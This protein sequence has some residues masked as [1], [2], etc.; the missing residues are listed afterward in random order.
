[1]TDP[2]LDKMLI[3]ILLN[4]FTN[5]SKLIKNLNTSG[6]LLSSIRLVLLLFYANNE[7]GKFFEDGR[8]M[9]IRLFLALHDQVI[10]A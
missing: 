9:T 2:V 3:P 8:V 4:N 1:M 5:I 6:L 10:E 7:S